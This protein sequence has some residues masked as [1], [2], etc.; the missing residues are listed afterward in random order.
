MDFLLV[1][2][3]AGQANAGYSRCGKTGSSEH[4]AQLGVRALWEAQLTQGLQNR[5]LVP[6]CRPQDYRL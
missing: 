4:E 5:S 1:E 3:F 2:K 6:G